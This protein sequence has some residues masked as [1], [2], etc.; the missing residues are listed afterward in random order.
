MDMSGMVNTFKR[1]NSTVVLLALALFTYIP[2]SE[3][4]V[5]WNIFWMGINV[6]TL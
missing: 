1:L 6:V 3:T 4:F 5:L 2:I